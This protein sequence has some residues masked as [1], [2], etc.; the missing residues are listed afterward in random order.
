MGGKGGLEDQEADGEDTLRYCST[1]SFESTLR[2]INVA[3]AV[4]S[5]AFVSNSNSD[6][7]SVTLV[8]DLDLFTTVFAAAVKRSKEGADIIRVGVDRAT[9]SCVA[10]LGEECSLSTTV[11]SASA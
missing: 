10:I 5:R 3:V 6:S 2:E 4:A 9:G 7:F 8:G 1:K 11:V